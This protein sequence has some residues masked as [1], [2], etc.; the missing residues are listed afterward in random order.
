M[1]RERIVFQWPRQRLFMA[2]N[3]L[4][5]KEFRMIPGWS[6]KTARG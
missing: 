6:R 4:N 5:V 1:E 3:V 2:F